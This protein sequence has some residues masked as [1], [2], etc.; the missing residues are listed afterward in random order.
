MLVWITVF[1]FIFF[2]AST[3]LSQPIHQGWDYRP[4]VSELWHYQTLKS[5]R[6]VL[7]YPDIMPEETARAFLEGRNEALQFVEDFLQV[8]LETPLTIQVNVSLI[9]PSGG[10]IA[11]YTPA[12]VYQI[13]FCRIQV[14]SLAT[15]SEG[16]VPAH[17]ETHVVA[18]Y[19]WGYITSRPL[20]EGLA[21]AVDFRS[22]PYNMIDPHLFSKGFSLKDELMPIE[23][24]FS[25]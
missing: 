11:W 15:S 2:S 6:I 21:V 17:E 19:R 4:T 25:G 13:P 18:N 12:I 3:V 10:A 7:Y 22:R 9:V 16:G 5:D 1:A 8:K 14:Q 23:A 24:L 20:G